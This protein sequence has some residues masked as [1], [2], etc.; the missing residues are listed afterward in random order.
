MLVTAPL[1]LLKTATATVT[2]APGDTL[3]KAP[4]TGITALSATVTC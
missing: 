2:T 4:D 1:I 3:T